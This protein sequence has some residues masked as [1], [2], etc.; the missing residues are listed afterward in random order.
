MKENHTWNAL[1]STLDIIQLCM[2]TNCEQCTGQLIHKPE[3]LT[4]VLN[5]NS[6]QCLKS[7]LYVY[8]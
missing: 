1:M 8:F 4:K 2:I 6:T 3:E 5:T 7:R